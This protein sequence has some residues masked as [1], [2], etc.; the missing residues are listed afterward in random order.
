MREKKRWLM[1]LS[2]CAMV[3][4]GIMGCGGNDTNA[5]ETAA[6]S[7]QEDAADE[8]TD[9]DETA[10]DPDENSAE[11]A[12]SGSETTEAETSDTAEE[13]TGVDPDLK[14]FLDSYEQVMNEYC[15]FMEKYN[16][17]DSTNQ[18]SMI[19]DYTSYM[20]SYME[21]ADKLAAYDQDEMSTEDLQY[22]LE[23]TNRVNQRLLSVAE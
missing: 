8:E 4:F 5:D 21:Y 19:A 17:A 15:D 20:T 12:D 22:Y 7:I 6:E 9:T 14:A 3:G 13:S 10:D 18:A 1:V 2:L 11:A 23:V 16:N